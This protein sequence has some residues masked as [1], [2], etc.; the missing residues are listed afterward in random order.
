MYHNFIGID[1]GKMEIY[2]ALYGSNK[3]SKYTNDDLGFKQMFKDFKSSISDSLVVLENTGGYEATLIAYLLSKNINV[4]RADTRRV[5]SFIRSTGRLGKSDTIDALGLAR[6]GKERHEEL[7]LYCAM[8][9]NAKELLQATNRR[10]ELKQIL[11]QEKNRLQSP[12]NASMKTSHQEFINFLNME[13]AKIEKLQKSLITA[14][15][16]LNAKV[17]LLKNDIDGIGEV[18]AINLMST[19]PELG[20][21]NRRQIASLAGLA[22]HPYESGKKI[23]YRSTRGGRETVKTILFMAALTASRSKKELGEFYRKLIARGKKPMVAL[24]A[25]MR[26]IVVIANAKIRD[27]ELDVA[28]V[29]TPQL[30]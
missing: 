11:V 21:L 5:K 25:L 1:I 20:S 27:M 7:K 19:L 30:A 24:T 14:N 10:I 18:T 29:K 15:K 26:K 13:I 22:P 3:V 23:G 4:H 28:V 8:E 16:E 12:D 9:T 2:V 17:E 6:Y